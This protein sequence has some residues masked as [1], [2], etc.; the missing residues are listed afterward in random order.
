VWFWT[1]YWACL[2][3]TVAATKSQ[4][5]AVIKTLARRAAR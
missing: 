1:L 5:A 2:H 4:A 3:E